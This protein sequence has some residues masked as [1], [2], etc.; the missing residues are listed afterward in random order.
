MSQ[1]EELLNS[2][3]ENDILAYTAEPEEEPHIVIGSDRFI[4]VPDV[5]KRI[6]V[7]FDHNIETVTFDCPRYWDEHDMSKMNVFI[8]YM[9]ADGFAGSYYVETVTIDETDSNIMHFDW[10][11]REEVTL[12]KG[13]LS[14]LVCIKKTDD[15]GNLENHWNSELNEEM[16]IS[17]GMNCQ[18]TIL[19]EYPDIVT[20]LLTRMEHVEYVARVEVFDDI[21]E[22]IGDLTRNLEVI[23]RCKNLLNP[24]INQYTSWYGISCQENTSTI[25][26]NK[27][28]FPYGYN[29]YNKTY[30]LNGTATNQAVFDLL[31]NEDAV[32]LLNSLS[33]KSVNIIASTNENVVLKIHVKTE[34]EEFDMFSNLDGTPSIYIVPNSPI[35]SATCQLIVDNGVTLTD[36]LVKPMIVDAEKTPN[37]TYDDFVPYIE[38]AETLEEDIFNI[39]KYLSAM[40]DDNKAGI[41]NLQNT[42]DR[43]VWVKGGAIALQFVLDYNSWTPKAWRRLQID[44]DDDRP[45]YHKTEDNWATSTK[46]P[47]AYL[48]ELTKVSD[49]LSDLKTSCEGL[50]SRVS[51]NATNISDLNTK[52]DSIH[53]S[54]STLST[55]TAS[56]ISDLNTKCD[57]LRSSINANATN[58][59]NVN[60]KCD[61]VYNTVKTNDTNVRA[62]ISESNT[63]L[64]KRIDDNYSALS[65]ADSAL[66][67]AINNQIT[68]TN[69]LC[70]SVVSVET[71]TAVTQ[72][73]SAGKNGTVSFTKPTTSGYSYTLLKVS[74]NTTQNVAVKSMSD[75]EARVHNNASS[76]ISVVFTPYWLKIRTSY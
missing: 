35:T 58:I 46:H 23:G 45:T 61:S 5:L 10:T 74:T 54:V 26:I 68:N 17:V 53:D 47:L 24:T 36:V 62:L 29:V 55:N 20:D 69:N 70:K 1:A 2:L 71:G 52:C 76:D 49:D 32:A 34:T 51:T 7:Q 40:I 12:I 14:F 60:A 48:E 18:E 13:K 31:S 75:S 39:I 50:N 42:L 66:S 3:S 9:R 57:S 11:I 8:N 6:A 56:S 19:S 25:N 67:Q 22:K 37:V 43:R 33:G 15:D 4:K 44:A 30:T 38:S 27:V 65:A 28:R 21:Y 16:Y 72:T 59:S 73:I 64:N 41:S 63:G